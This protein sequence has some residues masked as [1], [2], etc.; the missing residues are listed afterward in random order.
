M[1][2][3]ADFV[4]K[5]ILCLFGVIFLIVYAMT[6]NISYRY[7]TADQAEAE[8]YSKTYTCQIVQNNQTHVF[9]DC[10]LVDERI[11]KITFNG[12]HDEKT[13]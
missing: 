11:V 2:N 5:A 6:I 10:V 8:K 13:D 4:I 3:F 7:L 9:Q 12:G 1:T